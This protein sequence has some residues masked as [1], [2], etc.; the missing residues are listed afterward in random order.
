MIASSLT[1]LVHSSRKACLLASGAV[2][3]FL[4]SALPSHAQF[5]SGFVNYT[6]ANG[7]ASNDVT[8]V[9]VSGST[10]Y[11]G[12][13]NGLSISTDGGTNWT[14][15]LN[16]SITGSVTDIYVTGSKIYVGGYRGLKIST[17]GGAN[18]T[19]SGLGLSNVYGV[20]A[21]GSNIYVARSGGVSISTNSGANWTT[22]TTANGLG[23]NYAKNIYE[24]GGTIYAAT[25]GGVSIS[26]NGGANWTNYTTA[27]GLPSS[28]VQGVYASNGTIYV[29]SR[30][31]M[32]DETGNIVSPGALSI[33]I[34]AF[35]HTVSTSNITS[36]TATFRGEFAG[37]A[38]S[39]VTAR[40]FVYALASVSGPRIGDAGVTQVASG[41]GT[42]SYSK[43]LSGLSPNTAY[44]VRSYAVNSGG[45]TYSP[46]QN[47]STN[48]LPTS[49]VTYKTNN[50]LGNDR[51]NDIYASGD[52]I[53]AG[54]SGGLSISTNGGAN[55]TNYTTANGL[56]GNNVNDVYASGSTLYAATS[57]G[58]SISTNGGANW[59]NYTTANGLGDN[60]VYGVYVSGST[61]YAATN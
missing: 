32:D 60:N 59:T 40:G 39:P 27:N 50:G 44:V 49:F 47:F 11:A 17:D 3:A 5:P 61:L 4:A 13:R 33:G 1:H 41:S 42:G 28:N 52:T 43:L 31:D 30:G 45:T 51:V 20:Y 2:A 9:Y 16:G 21:S 36:S 12:T 46:V 58:V 35:S 10:I 53:Y 7:L 55:W 18:W 56:G 37:Q 29:A 6:T 25:E 38:T 15:N 23:S 24:S 8:D 57:G 22:Y 19:D 26:T 14:N 48:G 34:H 54:T